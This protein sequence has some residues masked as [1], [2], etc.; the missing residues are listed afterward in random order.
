[1]LVLSQRIDFQQPSTCLL[2]IGPVSLVHATAWMTWHYFIGLSK[3]KIVDSAQP[4][5]CSGVTWPFSLW[6][7][8][9]EHKTSWT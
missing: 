7:S 9:S 2:V 3:I 6:E 8:G 1:L 4:R 5:N